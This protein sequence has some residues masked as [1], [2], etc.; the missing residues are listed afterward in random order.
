MLVGT[1]MA[2]DTEFYEQRIAQERAAAAKAVD[3]IVR[4][5]HN[6]LADLYAE[7]LKAMSAR[8][9]SRARPT[10]TVAFDRASQTA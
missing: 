4:E 7:R 3:D 6:Q 1:D 2:R 9:E 10:L 8:D 5:R